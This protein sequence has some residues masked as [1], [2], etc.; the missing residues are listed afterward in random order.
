MSIWLPCSN[1]YQGICLLRG[2]YKNSSTQWKKLSSMISDI[3]SF[4]I[5]HIVVV[6]VVKSVSD[7]VAH[8]HMDIMGFT[9]FAYRFV[10]R[11]MLITLSCQS[12]MLLQM[13]LC[14]QRCTCSSVRGNKSQ[15]VLEGKR[16][17]RLSNP[18]C[19]ANK[20]RDLLG[21]AKAPKTRVQGGMWHLIS[22][23]VI[24][25]VDPRS[26]LTLSCTRSF[27]IPSRVV[28]LN[29]FHVDTKFALVTD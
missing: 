25:E 28:S 11:F 4:I 7:Q 15:L 18:I 16:M 1:L 17:A 22:P 23:S 14:S 3:N 8:I 2:P 26:F 20:A 24:P 29:V 10:Q 27:V 21:I 5:A 6:G 12:N 9:N 19:K 13:W